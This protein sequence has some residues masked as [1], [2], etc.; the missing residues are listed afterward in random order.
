M[1]TGNKIFPGTVSVV[2][3]RVV[4]SFIG[5]CHQR[6]VCVNSTEAKVIGHVCSGSLPKN[7][8]R[9]GEVGG[10]GVGS[11]RSWVGQYTVNGGR[12]GKT[13]I[14]QQNEAS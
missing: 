11:G 2:L 9:V 8:G 5:A 10:G 4:D 7:L 3:S 13:G 12:T 14:R 1:K 6:M